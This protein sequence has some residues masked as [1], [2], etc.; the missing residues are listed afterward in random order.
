MWVVIHICMEAMLGISLCSYLYL[1]LT[2]C[3]VFLNI[4]YVFSSTKWEI[5]RGNRCCP[6]V[7]GK[8]VQQEV[9]GVVQTMYTCK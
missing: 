9:E 1:K 2:K 8:E 7:G 3:Y 5:K 6:E 4:A